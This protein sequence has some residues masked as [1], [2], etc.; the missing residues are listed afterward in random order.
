MK[1]LHTP[2][3]W[4]LNDEQDNI[5]FVNDNNK[6]I[7]AIPM[8]ER[9]KKAN[10]KIRANAWLI[11]KVPEMFELIAYIGNDVTEINYEK[12]ILQRNE[13]RNKCKEFLNKYYKENK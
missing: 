6:E 7:C 9:S 4:E 13:Y 5:L 10:D 8:K 12:A 1:I 3:Q 11:A 2:G